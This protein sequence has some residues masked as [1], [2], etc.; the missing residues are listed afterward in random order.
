MKVIKVR[1]LEKE[2]ERSGY[3]LLPKRGKGNHRIYENP[4]THHTISVSGKK[5]NDVKPYQLKFWLKKS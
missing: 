2:L 1:L 3:Q 5:G 4:L